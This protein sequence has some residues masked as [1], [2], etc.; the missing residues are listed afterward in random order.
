MDAGTSKRAHGQDLPQELDESAAKRRRHAPSSGSQAAAPVM[1]HHHMNSS[2]HAGP[3][4]VNMSED[5]Q[6]LE[7]H[8]HVNVQWSAPTWRPPEGTVRSL[9]QLVTVGQRQP[10]VRI[11]RIPLINHQ[12]HLIWQ[13]LIE[14]RDHPMLEDPDGPAP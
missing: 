12:M 4:D 10:P 13:R 6:R 7:H 11:R 1:S 2:P 8:Q 3:Q 5:T 9:P 14:E